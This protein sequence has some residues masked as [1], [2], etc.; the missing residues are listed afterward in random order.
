MPGKPFCGAMN[1]RSGR[2]PTSEIPLLLRTVGSINS[3][4]RVNR[5]DIS[6][7]VS[8]IDLQE[9]FWKLTIF[10]KVRGHRWQTGGCQPEPG[11]NDAHRQHTDH[12]GDPQGVGD[13]VESGVQ[14][15]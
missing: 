3:D 15:R 8:T 7:V 9:T 12:D 4:K 2:Q 13:D 11:A 14:G 6:S 5:C 10:W 1:G